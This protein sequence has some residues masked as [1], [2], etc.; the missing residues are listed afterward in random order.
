MN[1]I[2]N[3]FSKDTCPFAEAELYELSERKQ[4]LLE[5]L[6]GLQELQALAATQ[7]GIAGGMYAG[8]YFSFRYSIKYIFLEF[9]FYPE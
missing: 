5:N 7:P 8:I 6:K 9:S 4:L 2:W 3:K 1:S